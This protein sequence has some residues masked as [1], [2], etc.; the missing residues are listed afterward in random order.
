MTRKKRGKLG[1]EEDWWNEN[2][3][4]VQTAKTPD[5]DH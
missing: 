5:S 4:M 1:Q 3:K 2:Y